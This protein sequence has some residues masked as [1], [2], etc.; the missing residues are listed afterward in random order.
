MKGETSKN[1][2]VVQEIKTDCDN[3]TLLIKVAPAGPTC[4]KGKYSC[5]GEENVNPRGELFG[6]FE[7]IQ[8]R[9]KKMPR[10]SYTASLF[11]A[12]TGKISLKVAEEALEVIQAANKQTKN[13]LTEETV[14]LL[15]HLFVL[16]ADKKISIAEIEKEIRKRKK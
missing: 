14:D 7:T 11:K 6:L 10:G 5:F 1:F 9:Q 15:Y 12:G 13:R 4:H 8:D 16:L 2:L 3:D